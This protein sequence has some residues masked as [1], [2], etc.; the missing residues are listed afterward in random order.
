MQKILVIFLAIEQLIW[1]ET[2]TEYTIDFKKGDVYTQ[3]YNKAS[4]CLLKNKE[5]NSKIVEFVCYDADN[6]KI[7]SFK[8]TSDENLTDNNA[9]LINITNKIQLTKIVFKDKDFDFTEKKEIKI[10]L[11]F[12]SIEEKELKIANNDENDLTSS[13]DQEPSIILEISKYSP[14]NW[15]WI[16]IGII[17]GLGLVGLVVCLYMRS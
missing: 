15:F 3:G 2:E 5:K 13:K 11:A 4:K 16:I 9:A 12:L 17:A 7:Q 1:C 14:T 8:L 10:S 6:N